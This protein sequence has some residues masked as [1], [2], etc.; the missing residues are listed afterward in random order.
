MR[1]IALA[2]AFVLTAATANAAQLMNIKGDWD[3]AET[4][5]RLQAAVENAGATVFARID[6][7]AGAAKVGQE[8]APNQLLIF[9][10]PKLGTPMMQSSASIGIDLPLKVH[11]YKNSAGETVIAYPDMKG[12]AEEHDVDSPTVGKAAGALEMLIGKATEE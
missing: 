4:M 12:L 10:N 7:A 2:A 3:V 6:H 5:D 11:I 9:G 8:L 1:L